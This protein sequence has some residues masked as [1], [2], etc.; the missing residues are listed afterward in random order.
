MIKFNN[1]YST[2]ILLAATG[3]GAG[4]LITGGLAG[5]NFGV[6]LIWA[7]YLGCNIKV[8]FK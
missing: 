1:K 6:S 3:V 2:G 8:F 5:I 7:M 4:D